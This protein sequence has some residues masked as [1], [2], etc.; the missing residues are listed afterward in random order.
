MKEP[1]RYV[2]YARGHRAPD[3]H[4]RIYVPVFTDP[5]IARSWLNFFIENEETVRDGDTILMD[6]GVKL[7]SE[8]LDAI[9]KSEPSA[10]LDGIHERRILRFKYGTWEERHDKPAPKVMV[11]NRTAEVIR[12]CRAVA[13]PGFVT[14]TELCVASGMPAPVARAALRASGRVK[15]DYGWA[16][17]PKEVQAI[18]A[19]CGMR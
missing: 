3:V 8:Q 4:S 14:I 1:Q 13:P 2:I 16:F 10:E 15:P 7:K 19:L 12:R 11:S 17:D 9:L 5:S 6:S 18:K